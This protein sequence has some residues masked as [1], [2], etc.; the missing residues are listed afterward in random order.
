[1]PTTSDVNIAAGGDRSESQGIH[2][3]MI[4]R[5]DCYDVYGF[6]FAVRWSIGRTHHGLS[7]SVLPPD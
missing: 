1:M 6:G 5:A 4:S 2:N 3:S 7:M